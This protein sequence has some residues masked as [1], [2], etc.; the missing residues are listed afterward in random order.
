MRTVATE[1][2]RLALLIVGLIILLGTA[3]RVEAA[4]VS[5][6]WDPSTNN[7]DGTPLTDLAGYRIYYGTTSQVFDAVID[8]GP[9]TTATVTNLL[10][11]ATY[12]FAVTCYD[13]FGV[14][15]AFSQELASTPILSGGSGAGEVPQMLCPSQPAWVGKTG[16]VVEWTGVPGVTYTVE[17]STN[18]MATASFIQIASRIPGQSPTAAYT[19]TSA[20]GRGPYFYRVRAEP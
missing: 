7:V 6:A 20:T 11:G 16:V 2:R 17:R 8:V 5:L 10:T 9:V 15:S 18:L 14:E 13:T 4:K 12:F 19:D 3:S 1:M